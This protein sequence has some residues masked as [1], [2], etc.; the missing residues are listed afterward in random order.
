MFDIDFEKHIGIAVT[1]TLA[2]LGLISRLIFRLYRTRILEFFESINSTLSKFWTSVAGT[3]RNY[4]WHSQLQKTLDSFFGKKLFTKKSWKAS[5]LHTASVCLL[6]GFLLLIIGI[7]PA[8]GSKFSSS[9]YYGVMYVLYSLVVFPFSIFLYN[10]VFDFGTIELNRFLI[11]KMES[12]NL[13]KIIDRK[14]VV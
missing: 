10:F 9:F 13:L 11:R 4:K 8:D 5:R 14:S 12:A 3:P 2:L 7:F 6:I 1:I